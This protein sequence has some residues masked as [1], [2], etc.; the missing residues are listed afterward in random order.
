MLQG[1]DEAKGQKEWLKCKILKTSINNPGLYAVL[2]HVPEFKE[3][4]VE[5]R[6]VTQWLQ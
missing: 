6:A 1:R 3:E 2:S 4:E 5:G